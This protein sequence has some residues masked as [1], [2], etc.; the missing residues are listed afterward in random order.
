MRL[1]TAIV[2]ILFV[3]GSWGNSAVAQIEGPLDTLLW[4]DI[5]TVTVVDD[6]VI[7]TTDDALVICNYDDNVKTFRVHH[8]MPVSY[9]PMKANLFDDSLLIIRTDDNKLVGYNI[10]QLPDLLYQWTIAPGI[11]FADYAIYGKTIFFSS[12]FHGVWQFQL[13]E[14]G[15]THFLDSSMVGILVTQLDVDSQYLYVLDTYNGIM[16]Y[17]LSQ[18]DLKRFVDYM[19]IPVEIESFVRDDNKFILRRRG[20]NSI[21][22]GSFNTFGQ[23]IHDSL[24]DIGYIQN[25]FVTPQNYILVE[26]RSI[27]IVN[28]FDTDSRTRIPCWGNSTKG[29]IFYTKGHPYLL[30]PRIA[31]GM[32]MFELDVPGTVTPGLYRSGPVTAMTFIDGHLFTSGGENPIDVF[33][34]NM[35]VLP[36]HD[37]TMF[38]QEHDIQTLTHNGDT[39][40][41]YFA[42][43]NKVAFIARS[44]EADSFFVER[45]FFLEDTLVGEMQYLTHKID[46]LRALI[47]IGETSI[48]AYTISDSLLI[49]PVSPWRFFGRIR[50]SVITDTLLITA[51]SK[52]QIWINRI[53]PDFSTEILALRDVEGTV[54]KLCVYKQILYVFIDEKVLL[55]GISELENF[56]L[57]RVVNLPLMVTDAIFIRDTLFATSAESIAIFKLEHGIPKLI[58]MQEGGGSMLAVDSVNGMIAVTDGRMI[59]LFHYSEKDTTITPN[60][61]L[62]NSYQL[63]QNY[64]NP[65]N[66]VTT[67]SFMLSQPQHV[68]VTIYNL[69]GQKVQTLLDEI[70]PAGN[71]ELFWDGTD[72]FGQPV[73]SGVYFYRFETGGMQ[74]TRKMVLLK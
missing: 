32:N 28:R 6:Y 56:Q 23:P 47:T 49:T 71:N 73:A 70:R 9:H 16:R 69:L 50:A 36:V 38:A 63:Y 7:G 54:R 2:F 37:Y 44:L 67:F 60:P 35:D 26:P 42:S 8:V 12:W 15:E 31:G 10:T 52:N 22:F 25:I 51:T 30:L 17:D 66:S 21:Y 40:I 72:R 18:N 20:G 55:Y 46:T 41:A 34:F 39:L 68:K 59:Q 53:K 45:S 33:S 24:T 43:Q 4:N 61:E 64:P 57:L 74:E 14:H 62:A 65:F 1:R 58:A 3:F 48:Q 13:G 11:P 27:H 29:D 5:Q 19:Y